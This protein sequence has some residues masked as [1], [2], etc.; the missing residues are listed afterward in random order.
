VG[1]KKDK[2]ESIG[3]WLKPFPSGVGGKKGGG[4]RAKKNSLKAA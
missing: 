2:D 1:K 3:K 4:G